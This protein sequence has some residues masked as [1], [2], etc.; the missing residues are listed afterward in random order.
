MYELIYAGKE[1]EELVKK[2][3]PQAVIKDA[4]DFVH[5]ERFECEIS[6]VTEDDF[7][8]FAISKGFARCCLG[9]ELHIES[10]RFPEREQNKHKETETR[11]EKW[12]QSAKS[13]D[14][15]ALKKE[16]IK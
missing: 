3:Y 14:A 9:F 10:L 4:S 1:V 2:K 16:E 8:P 15:E 11:I 13:L 5:R 6:D 12:I 7:Y